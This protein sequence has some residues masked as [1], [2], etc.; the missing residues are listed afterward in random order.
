M[1]GM[2]KSVSL[3]LFL[4]LINAASAIA[5]DVVVATGDGFV[6]Y[7]RDIDVLKD[8]YGTT[9]FETSSKEYTD[10]MLKIRLFAKEALALKLGGPLVADDSGALSEQTEMTMDIFQKLLQMYGLYV[11]YIYDSYSVSDAAIE[12]YYLSFPE[13]TT[14]SGD[15]LVNDF[16]RPDT[17]DEEMKR[18][19]RAKLIKNRKPRLLADEFKRLSDK[20][21]VKVLS[22]Y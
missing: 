19:I 13:K 2:Y 3:Y 14:R 7:S 18:I 9:G 20:Y 22:G 11:S 21:H 10:A 12:S 5:G 16:F 4:M 8:V 17:L 6:V 15:V 1:S